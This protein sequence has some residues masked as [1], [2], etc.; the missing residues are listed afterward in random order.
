VAGI[1]STIGTRGDDTITWAE[2]AATLNGRAGNDVITG[3]A[4]NDTL[5]GGAGND[6]LNGGAGTDTAVYS[7]NRA[8]YVITYNAATQTYTVADQ[9]A[10]ADGTDTVVNVEQFLFGDGTRAAASVADQAPSGATLAGGTVAENSA[11]GTVVGTVTG[12]DPDAWA[13][14]SY[15]LTNNAGGRFAINATTGVITVA[16]GTLLD[17][18]SATS[19]AITV[20]VTN[21]AG[22][23]FDKALT[24]SVTNVNEA[25]TNATLSNANVTEHSANGTVVGTVAGTDPDAG[26]TLTYS[27]TNNAGGRFAVN[28]TTGV[29][30]VAN[31]SLIDYATATSHTVTARVTDQG[32]LTFDKN[33]TIVVN[34]GNHAPTG[35][36]LSASTVAENAANGTVIGTVTGSDPDTW[37]SI[38]YSLTDNSGG[39]FAINATTGV[40]TVANAALLD[41]ALAPV[42]SITVRVTDQGGLTFDKVF[43]INVT[44]VGVVG[45]AGNDTLNTSSSGSRMFGLAGNDAL[46]GGTANDVLDGGTGN[47]T[48]QGS[49]GNDT[50]A[51]NR[52]DGTDTIYDDY[53]TYSTQTVWVDN[54]VWVSSGYYA[55]AYNTDWVDT[56]GWQDQGWYETDTIV[57]RYDAG[58]DTLALGAGIHA[59]DVVIRLSGNDLLVGVKDPAAPNA[60][61][62]QLTDKLTLQSWMDP[63]NRIENI[64]VDGTSRTLI[65]ATAANTTAVAATGNNWLVGLAANQTLQAGTGNDVLEG[66]GGN[67]TL[68]GGGGYDTYVFARGDGQNIVVNGVAGNTGPTG[69]LDFGQEIGTSQLWLKQSGANLTISVLGTQD[70]VTV[71]NWFGSNTAKLQEIKAGGVQIDSSVASLVQAMATYSTNNP[72][73]NPTTATQM[74]SDPTLQSAIAA[75]WH[76]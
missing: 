70:Q 26:A 58:N 2:S 36:N 30:T 16:N 1:V 25:P 39:R 9:R 74:P 33:F 22:L 34:T 50:Y 17:Y 20:R 60:T 73:F 15:S 45:T 66:V 76:H 51:F 27:L 35:A 61:F 4:F 11:N 57:T 42:D 24:V 62:A 63:L 29:L 47:D 38:S 18:E 3:S 71:S 72:A 12:G 55:G 40:V 41:A 28:A 6:T 59:A 68:T 7:G 31:G 53:R 19:H 52:G 48:L 64:W 54:W 49:Y 67:D 75:A 13:T 8:N 10:N 5:I 37:G 23:T 14:L 69:E 46:N 44:P 43:A 32:G 56:S 65:V 21:Q